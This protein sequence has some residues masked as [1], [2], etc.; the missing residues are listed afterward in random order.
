[1]E[2]PR[3][4]ARADEMRRKSL[5]DPGGMRVVEGE[6]RR[7]RRH[8]PRVGVDR[9]GGL[10]GFPDVAPQAAIA[11]SDEVAAGTVTVRDM[12]ASTQTT[13]PQGEVVAYLAER[14][15]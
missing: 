11:G 1:M 5:D 3:H 13:L 6:R 2:R 7:P 10:P 15:G 4:D 9:L 14:L 12:A 8:G